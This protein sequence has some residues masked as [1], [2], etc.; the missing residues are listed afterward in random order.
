[1]SKKKYVR[2]TLTWEGRRYEVRGE[3][4][5]E[6]VEK[7]AV[8]RQQ[9]ERG[10]KTEGG[11]Q[12]VTTWF[13]SW[14]DV[15]KVPK[16][17]SPSSLKIYF[18]LYDTYIGPVIGG[19]PLRS[20]RDVHLQRIMNSAEGASH[21]TA[22]KLRILLRALFKQARRSRMIVFDPSEALV[23][24]ATKKGERRSLTSEERSA[25][26]KTAETHWAGLYLLTILYAG[27]RPGEAAVL[28]WKD[29][30]F[31]ANEIHVYKAMNNDTGEIK[32]PKTAAGMRDI[33]MQ[34]VLREK[35]L[36]AEGDPFQHVFLSARGKPMSP[37][38]RKTAWSSFK[39]AMAANIP[40]GYVSDDLT[41]YCL[42][43]TFCTDLQRAGVPIN[44]AKDLMGHSDISITAN[45]YTH[46]D[47]NL[48]HENIKRLDAVGISV[49]LQDQ[50]PE[51]HLKSTPLGDIPLSRKTN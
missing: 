13:R 49:G 40:G 25:L 19:L 42:R 7:L 23:L 37:P 35:L 34:S 2:K 11:D 16:K 3:T 28:L 1:M 44:V 15:Y 17:L 9:L 8:L 32:D 41:P 6:A 30:D 29:V 51:T 18:W 47:Q 39:K 46:R 43:H 20:V 5:R 14:I 45:I 24:P 36:A 31:R 22:T 27:L 26:L 48:L 21:S 4:E 10:E 38:V 50:K 12:T 33:P